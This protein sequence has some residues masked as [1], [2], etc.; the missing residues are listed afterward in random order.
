MKKIKL[1]CIFVLFILAPLNSLD[2]ENIKFNGGIEPVYKENMIYE[3]V[4]YYYFNNGSYKLW[5]SLDW[6]EPKNRDVPDQYI[7][8]IGYLENGDYSLRSLNEFNYINFVSNND[9]TLK[10]ELGVLFHPR[11]L[12]LYDKDMLYFISNDG[13]RYD[14]LTVTLKPQIDMLR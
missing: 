3:S 8:D 9:F 13:I 5:H 14:G 1:I 10:E 4:S 7:I 2:F 11:C 6:V 12:A